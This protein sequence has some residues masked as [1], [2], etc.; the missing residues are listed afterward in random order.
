MITIGTRCAER[1]CAVAT[2][3][4]SLSLMLASLVS[5]VMATVFDNAVFH[6]TRIH[7][8]ALYNSQ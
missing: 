4:S 8:G 3:P 1:D 6:G 5:A 7:D 2:A